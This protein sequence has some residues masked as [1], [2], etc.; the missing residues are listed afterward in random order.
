MFMFIYKY[1]FLLIL[2]S[3]PLGVDWEKIH[4]YYP[5]I[6]GYSYYLGDVDWG[7]VVYIS[8]EDLLGLESEVQLYFD[9]KKISKA[10]L[11]LGPE[12]LNDYNCV[13]KYKKVRKLLSDKYGE[14]KYI[15]ERKDPIIDDLVGTSVCYT[16]ALGLYEVSTYWTHGKY[17]I[18]CKLIGDYEGYYIEVTYIDNNKI[19]KYNQNQKN[20]IMKKL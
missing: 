18:E 5:N 9:K 10:I 11:V 7:T 19:K 17:L 14:Y 2:V 20:K 4:K 3:F 12:G 6:S 1:L 13:K 8:K 15:K 16:T